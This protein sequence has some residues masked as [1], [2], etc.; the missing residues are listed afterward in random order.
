MSSQFL[1]LDCNAG[2]RPLL[3]QSPCVGGKTVSR[4]KSTIFWDIA[5]CSPM[6]VNRSFG[7][8]HHLHLQGRRI[9]K[10]CLLP[11]FTLVSCSVY[12]STL[13][14]EVIYFSEVSVEFQRTIWCYIPKDIALH[15]HCFENIISYTVSKMSYTK[16]SFARLITREEFLAE[17]PVLQD[18]RGLYLLY[19]CMLPSVLWGNHSPAIRFL[20]TKNILHCVVFWP[21]TQHIFKQT[22]S[23]S[24]H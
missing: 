7:G 4:T 3:M 21:S 23:F 17:Q 12:S 1:S 18:T 10:I 5:P 11:V 2:Q 9:R 15:N 24:L 6:K 20:P 8:T 19:N 14:M 13:K 16:S 22:N